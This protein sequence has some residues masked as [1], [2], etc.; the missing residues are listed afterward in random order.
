MLSLPRLGVRSGSGR[1]I[2]AVAPRREEGTNQPTV[3][4]END[5]LDTEAGNDDDDD[6]DDGCGGGVARR[7]TQRVISAACNWL[8]CRLELAKLFD[9]RLDNK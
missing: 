5:T 4:Y 9:S 6:D 1:S 7:N 8:F 3:K 2:A